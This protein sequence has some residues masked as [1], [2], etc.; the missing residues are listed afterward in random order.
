MECCWVTA[1][2]FDR[3]QEKLWQ[4][5]Y[6]QLGLKN[7]IFVADR[8]SDEFLHKKASVVQLHLV[9]LLILC[10]QCEDRADDQ[11]LNIRA[12]T[13]D[14]VLSHGWVFP[15]SQSRYLLLHFL[16]KKKPRFCFGVVNIWTFLL[17]WLD[18]FIPMCLIFWRNLDF[19]F[20]DNCGWNL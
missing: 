14:A 18:F 4:Y 7:H 5:C 15:T 2:K 1:K 10:R 16:Y 13:Y 11:C 8:F 3:L 20:L 9:W 12:L 17:S 6:S 19:Y